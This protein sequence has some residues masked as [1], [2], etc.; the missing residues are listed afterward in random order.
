MIRAAA[1]NFENVLVIADKS[2]YN[3]LENILENQNAET[4]L[5]ERKSFA[6]K[7]FDVCSGYDIAISNYFNNTSFAN[8]F[9]SQKTVLRYGENPH[10]QA[11]FAG[12]L[13]E[14]FDQLNGK[15]LSYNNIVDVDAAINLM[16]DFKTPSSEK[17]S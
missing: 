3:K 8:P 12:N 10:Q 1:K 17:D 9:A 13:S 7:A 16:N 11:T 6:A 2:D 14:L 5:E 15:E 4:S